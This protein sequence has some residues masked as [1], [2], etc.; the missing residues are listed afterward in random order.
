VLRDAP[1]FFYERLPK[2][3]NQSFRL[4]EPAFQ[5]DCADQRFDDVADDSVALAGAVAARLLAE[6]DERREAEAAADFGAGLARD[7][8]I[9]AL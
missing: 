7:K 5:I 8:C 2:P 6:P 1:L 3:S 4:I 9:V